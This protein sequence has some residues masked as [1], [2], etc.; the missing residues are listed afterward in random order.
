MISHSSFAP[1]RNRGLSHSNSPAN[2]GVCVLASS[3][4]LRATQRLQPCCLLGM[5]CTP[6]PLA[7]A[8]S[9]LDLINHLV[10]SKFPDHSPNIST[11]SS[12]F[13][14]ATKISTNSSFEIFPARHSPCRR[15][16][17]IHFATK[18]HP[19]RD[20]EYSE[21]HP[22]LHHLPVRLISRQKSG[23]HCRIISPRLKTR[24]VLDIPG[25]A[26][27]ATNL[28]PER[29]EGSDPCLFRR[30]AFI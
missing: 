10:Q 4:S 17:R 25:K 24:P 2:Q 9:N 19:Q 5:D 29:L 7:P 8:S 15:S 27:F 16:R 18:F 26:P 20:H 13:E 30:T 22:V 28:A 3:S 21:R 12:N 11:A 1:W 14:P 6:R 23:P